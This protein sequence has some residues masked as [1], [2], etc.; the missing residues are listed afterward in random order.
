[1]THRS[2]LV[3]AGA[4]AAGTIALPGAAHAAPAFTALK[5]CYVSVA[6][7]AGSD[8][9]IEPID[10]AGAG[11]TPNSRVDVTVNGAP[12]VTGGLVDAAGRLD[13]V[14]QSPLVAGRRPQPFEI[15][16]TEQG[17]SAPAVVA[18]SRAVELV[19]A[20][21]PANALARSKVRFS[22]SGFTGKGRRVYAHYRYKNKTRKTISFKKRGP[23]GTFSARRRQFPIRNPASGEWTVQFDGFKRYR[24][25]NL[26]LFPIKITVTRTVRFD[27]DAFSSG[28][29]AR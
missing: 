18:S 28:W 1:M 13:A 6:A 9:Q 2:R 3:L 20:L 5:P 4:V 14:A 29:R 23:C 11:F 26:P 16:A 24:A 19:V 7:A 10:L 25:S 22:G 15:V 21:D 27:R 17:A 12:S 8:A